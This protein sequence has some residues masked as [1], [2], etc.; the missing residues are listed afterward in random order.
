MVALFV[1]TTKYKLDV[2]EFKTRCWLGARRLGRLDLG[3]GRMGRLSSL[4]VLEGQFE[5]LDVCRIPARR[6][7]VEL[8][9]AR[10]DLLKGEDR[11]LLKMYL[12]AG[13]SFYQLARLAGMNRSTVCRR[14][15]RMIRRLSDETYPVC[16]A[17][18]HV[19]DEQELTIIRDH[20]VRGLS[21]KR[22]CRDHQIGLYRVRVTVE[23]ARRFARAKEAP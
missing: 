15:H 2:E 8:L 4:E 5:E 6:D 11:A 10:L 14:I 22:I 7:T 21:V 1:L 16:Q 3:V 17:N 23:K 20:F 13:S 19:F 9:R 18:P 12:D